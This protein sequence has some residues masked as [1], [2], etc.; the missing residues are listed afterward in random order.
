MGDDNHRDLLIPL[1]GHEQFRDLVSG[2]A[3]EIGPRYQTLW[4]EVEIR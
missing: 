3:I 1:E 2:G 4:Y